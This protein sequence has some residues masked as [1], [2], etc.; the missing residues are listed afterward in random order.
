[1]ESYGV[2]LK[3]KKVQAAQT[4][5]LLPISTLCDCVCSALKKRFDRAGLLK[6]IVAE[7]P[8][9]AECFQMP[10]GRPPCLFL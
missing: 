6:A 5:G 9:M 7:R 3:I 4:G 10:P 1:M 2:P 8:D